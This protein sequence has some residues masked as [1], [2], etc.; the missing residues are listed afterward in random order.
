MSQ[1]SLAYAKQQVT[2][3]DQGCLCFRIVNDRGCIRVGGVHDHRRLDMGAPP[4]YAHV[5][6]F[7]HEYTV[8][9]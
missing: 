3:D 7:N 1:G 6:L 5:V 4:G 9:P 8:A 2:A